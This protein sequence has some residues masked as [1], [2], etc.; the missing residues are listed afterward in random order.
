MLPTVKTPKLKA[1]VFTAAI[2]RLAVSEDDFWK[3]VKKP[4]R[5][6]HGCCAA[7]ATGDYLHHV[8]QRTFAQL[9]KNEENSFVFWWG[10]ITPENQT[11]RII[12]LQLAALLV[13]EGNTA[14]HP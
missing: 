1:A 8:E 12:A 14:I 6:H 4:H 5:G 10:H 9:F 11:A 7:I 2:P 13:A 3:L